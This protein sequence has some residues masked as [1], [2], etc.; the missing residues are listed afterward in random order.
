MVIPPGRLMQMKRLALV[1]LVALVA[2]VAPAFA[3]VTIKSTMTGKGFG[4]G[5]TTTYQILVEN[6]GTQS[7]YDVVISAKLSPEL[8]L[9]TSAKQQPALRLYESFGFAP[10][11]AWGEY[12]ATPGTSLCFSK[13][14]AD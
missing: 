12:V 9:E 8:K 13:R 3:D 2:P 6:K 5:G 11:A 7:A 1:A 4:V 14:L 10:C